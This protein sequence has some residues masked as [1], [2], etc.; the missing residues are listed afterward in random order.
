M[1]VTFEFGSPEAY[2]TFTNDHG[3]PVLQKMLAS[4]TIEKRDRIMIAI[5]K[6]AQMYAENIAGKVRFENEVI[7]IVGK[8]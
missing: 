1:N 8:K 2:T 7:L 4:Q 5:S 3:D 6:A